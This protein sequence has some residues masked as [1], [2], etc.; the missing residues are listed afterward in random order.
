[1]ERKED[2][3]KGTGRY[4]SVLAAWGLSVGYAVGWGAFV[5]PGTFRIAELMAVLA[6]HLG[7][8][9]TGIG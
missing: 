7:E 2:S 5:M 1:M 9:G 8:R 3:A 4:L 6:R